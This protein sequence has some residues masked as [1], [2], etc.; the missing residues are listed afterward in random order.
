MN[1]GNI[2]NVIINHSSYSI[3]K[4]NENSCILSL[5]NMSYASGNILYQSIIRTHENTLGFIDPIKK[6]LHF[7]ICSHVYNLLD[8]FKT[9]GRI[10]YLQC[11]LMIGFLSK[12]IKQL[13]EMNY[14]LLGFDLEDIIVIDDYIFVFVNNKYLLPF[15]KYEYNKDRV[16]SLLAPIKKPYFSSPELIEIIKIPT[17]IHYKSS[18]YSLASL[19]I[20]FLLDEYMFKG[21]EVKTDED[22]ETIL[23]PIHCTKMYWFLKRCLVSSPAKRVLLF[24]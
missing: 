2:Q 5:H 19:V 17:Q 1:K 12:Q 22:I 24:I 9:K 11:M 16:V 13:E 14:C 10:S 23:R 21:N 6:E 4:D 3:I 8:F 7:R 15:D 18:Y 20:Y